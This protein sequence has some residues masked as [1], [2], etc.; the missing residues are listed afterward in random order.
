MQKY[1]I[2]Q[3]GGC[4]ENEYLAITA[5]EASLAPS[6]P[7]RRLCLSYDH[8]TKVDQSCTGSDRSVSHS[9]SKC[10]VKASKARRHMKRE[11]QTRS[12]YADADMYIILS[13]HEANHA[14]SFWASK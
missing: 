13:G 6:A 4:S 10:N 3:M 7:P 5:C 2:V 12:K 1:H 8:K 9:G 14:R 11:Q